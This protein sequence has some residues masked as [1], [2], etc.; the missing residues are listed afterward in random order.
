MKPLRLEAQSKIALPFENS[1][2]ST[3]FLEVFPLAF[4]FFNMSIFFCTK[5]N[6]MVC[7]KN[8]LDA[9]YFGTNL[10]KA[11]QEKGRFF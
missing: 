2:I 1:I 3:F 10:R 9:Y 7:N 5:R 11:K 4:P 8:M 6:N